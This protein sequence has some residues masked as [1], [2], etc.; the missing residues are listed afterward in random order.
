MGQDINFLAHNVL[1]FLPLFQ[2]YLNVRLIAMAVVGYG[3]LQESTPEHQLVTTLKLLI[4]WI[5]SQ[6]KQQNCQEIPKLPKNA[7]MVIILARI[8]NHL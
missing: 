4:K 1:V 8:H 6:A 3:A 2:K 5:E 7:S